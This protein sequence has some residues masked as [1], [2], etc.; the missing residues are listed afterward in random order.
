MNKAESPENIVNKD[1]LTFVI[2][3]K[4]Y[5]FPILYLEGVI[6]N[7]NI[8]TLG[9]APNFVVG[10]FCINNSCVPI[11]DLRIILNK[12]NLIY[13]Q[14]TCVIIVR[15]SFKGAEKLVGFIVDSFDSIF[16]IRIGNIEKL[17]FSECEEFITGLVNEKDKMILI[18][19][20]EKII[21]SENVISYLN[22]F[23]DNHENNKII[24]KNPNGK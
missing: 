21:N 19:N 10:D 22:E 8:I 17:P 4:T 6:G 3:D 9:E 16:H 15:A 12:P 24:K 18:L 13:P 5:A 20:L 1:I 7:P 23:W 2:D 11:M 14:K